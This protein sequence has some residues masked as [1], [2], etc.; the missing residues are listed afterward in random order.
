MRTIPTLM[1]SLAL[2]AGAF[3]GELDNFAK[4]WKTSNEFNIAVAEAMPAPD[5][6]FAP[7]AEEMGFGKL[8]IHFAG[9]NNML[10]GAVSGMKPPAVPEKMA[11]AMKDPKGVFEKE[12]VVQ[13]LKDSN[14]FTEK[15]LAEITPDKLDQ[16]F[17]PE[18]RQAAGRE[19]LMSGYVHTVHHR[20]QAE[21][22]LR[23][24]GIK[25]PSY[26]F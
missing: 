21:V 7:N 2:A 13:F 22:Y 24:K 18:G 17:G 16:M 14:A 20:G 15:A 8:M 3:A 4:H 12:A 5:Y 10:F 25:P 11:A 6:N 1:L 19:R 26:K 9:Y 23:V